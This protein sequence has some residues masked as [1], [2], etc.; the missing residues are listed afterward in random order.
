MKK[1]TEIKQRISLIIDDIG[2]NMSELGRRL[3]LKP[4]HLSM[5]MSTDSGISATVL[6][7]L[8]A[9]GINM[10][11]LMS[12][13]GSEIW[14][15]DLNPNEEAELRITAI[16]NELKDANTLINSLERILKN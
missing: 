11:W 7:N 8:A 13:I 2:G 10:N 14:V 15:A 5:V 16:S 3:D 9:I 1:D 12:G 6:K 4:G